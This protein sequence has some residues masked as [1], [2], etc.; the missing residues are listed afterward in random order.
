[1][2][3]VLLATVLFSFVGPVAKLV[4][5]HAGPLSFYRAAFAT[6]ALSLA[7]RLGARGLRLAPPSTSHSGGSKTRTTLVLLALGLLVSGN[8]Y[9]Y[10]RA[11]Q[12]SSVAI[13][14]V[15]LFTY[16]L[17]TSLLEPVVFRQAYR[18]WDIFGGLL[19]LAG[20]FTIVERFDW[21][22][23]SAQGAAYGLLASI[24]LTLRNVW[25]RRALRHHSPATLTLVQFSV[26][27]CV[28]SPF[29]WTSEL[30][31]LRSLLLLVVIGGVLTMVS[32]FLFI[33]ALAHLST[34]R[35][36]LIVSLQPILATLIAVALLGEVPG[37]RTLTGGVL[38]LAA[39]L[40]GL[41]TQPAPRRLTLKR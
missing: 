18:F 19:V 21:D 20:V 22:E 39:V 4:P 2:Q 11:V 10:V 28:F 16:P 41:L 31:E 27:T 34:A 6:L 25:S 40:M 26:A 7:I 17:F 35:A 33:A 12:V 32:Q 24:S 3:N 13:A 37:P 9:F 23:S 29:L 38:I 14:V 5:L 15:C 36:S 8:W 1:M 30:P